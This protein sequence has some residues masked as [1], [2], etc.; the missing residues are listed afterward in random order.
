MLHYRQSRNFELHDSPR[1]P[2][3]R[4]RAFEEKQ[5][6]Y[7]VLKKMKLMCVL[8]LHQ[9]TLLLPASRR[10]PH[11]G[12]LSYR[13]ALSLLNTIYPVSELSRPEHPPCVPPPRKNSCP[14]RP[15]RDGAASDNFNLTPRSIRAASVLLRCLCNQP[16]KRMAN[17]VKQYIIH[18]PQ[19][20]G[21]HT[22]EHFKT[23]A[24]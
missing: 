9:N 10:H 6:N 3:K 7:V 22:N 2:Q 24:P 20:D 23:H 11:A 15:C 8:S 4:T 21:P 14:R 13:M 17:N 16:A 19:F 5:L 1:G 18:V 12:P